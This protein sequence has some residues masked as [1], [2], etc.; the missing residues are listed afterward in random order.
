[1]GR[2]Q[3]RRPGR[4]GLAGLRRRRRD[5]GRF[6]PHARRNPERSKVPRRQCGRD[7]GRYGAQTLLSVRVCAT[8]REM[9]RAPTE[10]AQ[11]EVSVQGRRFA[12]PVGRP[13][14]RPMI[15]AYYSIVRVLTSMTPSFVRW[16]LTVA[17][18]WSFLSLFMSASLAISFPF[19]SNF[20]NLPSTTAP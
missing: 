4:A 11:T 10:G 5:R 17:W 15:G 2:R 13:G 16:P 8:C 19:S 18:R 9:K 6:A 7:P 1:M 3:K 12:R 20:T 14:G